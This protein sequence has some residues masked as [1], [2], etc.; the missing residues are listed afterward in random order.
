MT[1]D[2]LL[3]L[4]EIRQVLARYCRGI[5]RADREL[6]RSVYHPDGTDHHGPVSGT[7]EHFIDQFIARVEA[8]QAA[9]DPTCAMHH[10]T[11]VLLLSR[12]EDT[13][14]AE[15]YFIAFNPR[16]PADD[17]VLGWS[18]GRYLDVFRRHGGEWKILE[19]EVLI[20]FSRHQVP[21]EVDPM[22]DAEFPHGTRTSA[23]PSYEF[24]ARTIGTAPA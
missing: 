18:A 1:L 12:T 5:D 21:G 13:A 3:V 7:A 6:L 10:V 8:E 24:I 14:V 23:D 2:D 22:L 11:N 16:G 4:E 15:S 20:D 17:R 19:R 9:G